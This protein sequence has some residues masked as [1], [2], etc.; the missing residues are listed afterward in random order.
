MERLLAAP[1][2]AR[3]EELPAER[4][5][6]RL[7]GQP[8]HLVPESFLR[9]QAWEDLA[10]RRLFLN[11]GCWIAR[12]G[13]LPPDAVGSESP[14]EKFALQG[15]IAWVTDPGSGVLQPFWLGRN[16]ALAL[17][18]VLPGDRAPASLPSEARMVLMMAGVLVEEGHVA[19]RRREWT[20]TAL[21][22]AA[23]F[24]QRGFAPM[25]GLIHPFLVSAL[26]R[27]YRYLI[28][29]GELH[30]G[31]QQTAQRYV[32][33]NE[34]VARFFHHQLTPAMSA[35]AGVKVKPS[36]VYMGS[37]QA[38]AILK[39]HTDREQC[40]YSITFCLDYSPEPARE[41]PWPLRLEGDGGAV[42]VFQSIGDALFYKGR[43]LVHSREEL[44][45][46]NTSTSIFF[47]Y[48][49][50]DFSGSLE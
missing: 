14:L 22:C 11:P 24:R 32:A 31:D 29:S 37:Y 33:H 40:E 3:E 18:G 4:F 41:T 39:K 46:G 2:P 36:Y 5:Y 9:G 15:T 16:L 13:S 34:S 7:D 45:E 17:E 49:A 28:R 42:T 12:N 20:G 38:G 23:Q 43:E 6:C 25:A 27:Y 19:R 10:G 48:V 30:L 35:V 21:H 47:H 26:R 44:P 8:D 50:E 1:P